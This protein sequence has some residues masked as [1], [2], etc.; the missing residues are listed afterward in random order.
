MGRMLLGLYKKFMFI[1]QRRRI[2]N[3]KIIF[4]CYLIL[5]VFPIIVY[6]QMITQEGF[7]NYLINKR[8]NLKKSFIEY[9]R[10][11]FI[12][13]NKNKYNDFLSK[14]KYKKIKEISEILSDFITN[15]N[16]DNIKIVEV[17]YAFESPETFPYEMEYLFE[18]FSKT[19]HIEKDLNT[20]LKKLIKQKKI[21]NGKELLTIKSYCNEKKQI[22]TEKNKE[23]KSDFFGFGELVQIDYS[24]TLIEKLKTKEYKLSSDGNYYTINLADNSIMEFDC[25]KSCSATHTVAYKEG[26]ILDERWFWNH[27]KVGNVHLPFTSS[28]MQL[29]GDGKVIHK[30]YLIKNVYENFD[31]SK[32]IKEDDI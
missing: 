14:I 10:Y 13:E 4:Y 22:N 8:K 31:K 3:F 18:D 11:E 28:I 2:R 25:S 23:M 6:S 19:I 24:L 27:K 15:K 9:S 12:W 26:E 21:W 30:L 1:M 7:F 16:H 20:K 5:L 17:K 29:K 32:L